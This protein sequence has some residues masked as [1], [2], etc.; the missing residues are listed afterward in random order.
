MCTEPL[1]AIR[2]KTEY[3]KKFQRFKIR[4]PIKVL[5]SVKEIGK[6]T[7]KLN[8]N[9]DVYDLLM[10]SCGQCMQCRLQRVK[11]RAV[12]SICESLEHT[13]NSFV[14]LTFGFP[15]TYSYYRHKVGLSHYLSKKKAHFHEWSLDVET[16]QKFMKRL[17]K[18]YYNYQLCNHL[19]SIG[20]SERGKR[21]CVT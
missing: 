13:E 9:R 14:T 10:I 16:F 12:M 7:S 11:Q 17:R 1:Y 21:T 6:D 5:C 15:Q 20:R 19:I 18:W 4:T 2:L 3:D 8:Y